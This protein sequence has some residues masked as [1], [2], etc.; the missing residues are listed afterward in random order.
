ML[1]S[2]PSATCSSCR[3]SAVLPC[4]QARHRSYRAP[5]RPRAIR[6]LLI[7]AACDT[8]IRCHKPVPG[9]DPQRQTGCLAASSRNQT[10]A[11]LFSWDSLRAQ[12]DG[13]ASAPILSLWLRARWSSVA[14]ARNLCS[15]SI[16]EVAKQGVDVE[17]LVCYE[18][19]PSLVSTCGRGLGSRPSV[20]HLVL[21]SAPIV[22]GV[23]SWED[24]SASTVPS[25]QEAPHSPPCCSQLPSSVS[26]RPVRRTHA[27]VSQGRVSHC[28]FRATACAPLCL[29]CP[30][31]RAKLH[32]SS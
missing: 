1:V 7:A 8:C 31:L 10:V 22:V 6:K 25:T 21:L 12:C 11:G 23:A 29:C 2:R 5:T 24:T 19:Q 9:P 30:W 17:A 32:H 26:V 14:P 4:T 28:T 16:T 20:D 27:R 18:L 3:P 15:R 13:L